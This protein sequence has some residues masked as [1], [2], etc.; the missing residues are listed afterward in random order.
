MASDTTH[1]KTFIALENNP[2]VFSH[3]IHHLGVSPTLAFHDIYSL[4]SPSLLAL[5]PRP[6]YALIFICPAAVFFRARGAENDAMTA[7]T[8]SGPGEPIL[9]IRQ[10]IR[11]SCGLMALLHA[12]CNGPARSHIRPTSPLAAFIEA[13]VPLQPTER[14]RL[15]YDD[16]DIEAAHKSAAQLGDSPAGELKVAEGEEYGYHFLTFVKGDDGHLWELNG[17][18]EGPVDRG[19]LG[20]GEDVLSERGLDLGVKTFLGEDVLRGEVGFSLVALAA[21]EV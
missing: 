5:I 12:I 16:P 15:L 13:A 6:A 18:M 1:P 14:A 10:T 21:E 20:E 19:L 17:G 8:S 9:W 7:Y 2:A 4:S 3:L 11:H